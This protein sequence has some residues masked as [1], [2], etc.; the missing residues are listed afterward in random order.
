MFRDCLTLTRLRYRLSEDSVDLIDALGTPERAQVMGDLD[1]LKAAVLNLLDNAVK[2]SGDKVRVIVELNQP[3]P[4]QVA[5]KVV[6]EGMG[7]PAHE[8]KRIFSRFYRVPGSA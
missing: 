4:K 3:D 6:D 8:L 1:E 2:Y 5:V 7:I